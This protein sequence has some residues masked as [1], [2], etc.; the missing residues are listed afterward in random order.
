MVSGFCLVSNASHYP[1][2]E[3]IKS[4]LPVLDELVVVASE[5]DIQAVKKIDKGIRIIKGKWERD[6]TYWRMNYNFNKG[7]EA[8]KGDIVLKFD[9]DRILHEGDYGLFRQDIKKTIDNGHITLTIA[10]RNV[11]IVDRYAEQ[12]R[13]ALVLNRKK[14][15]IKFGIDYET[16]GFHNNFVVFKE[17]KYKLNLGKVIGDFGSSLESSVREYNYS[18]CFFTKEQTIE[19]YYRYHNAI[20]KQKKLMGLP[21]KLITRKEAQDLLK[22]TMIEKGIDKCTKLKLEEHPKVIQDRIRNL[23]PEQMGYSYWGIEKAS[24]YV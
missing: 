13:H 21:Y 2:E 23:K 17:K 18:C 22:E 1:F 7:F 12:K 9:A 24:Y 16:V 8:C 19:K 5:P 20:E 4:W 14:E 11:R 3:A 10:R 15:M 6:W